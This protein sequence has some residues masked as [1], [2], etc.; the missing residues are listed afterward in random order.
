MVK[1]IKNKIHNGSSAFQFR[2]ILVVLM[3]F[4]LLPLTS[5]HAE[6][7]PYQTNNN[8]SCFAYA[9]TES[10][11]HLFLL[12]TNKSAFGSNVTIKHNCEY[13]EVYSNG[14]F[15]AYTESNQIIVPFNLGLNNIE[16]KSANYS[17]NIS[18]VFI[19]P[20]RLNWQF[21]FYEWENRNNLEITQFI[22][23]VKAQSRE[24]WASILSI[25]MVFSLVTMVYWNLINSY[26]DRNY[27]EE[28]TK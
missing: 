6:E 3:V 9:Y 11:D 26:I 12:E 18:N 14:S 16:I 25:V 17:K 15:I 4:L 10:I 7:P 1:S 28:V 22:S 20:D 19:Y 23:L 21:E 24:N 13:L 8:S 27:C 2:H 5:V